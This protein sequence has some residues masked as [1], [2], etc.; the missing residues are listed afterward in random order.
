[1][2]V[3]MSCVLLG[4]HA[5]VGQSEPPKTTSTT[6]DAPAVD[7]KGYGAKEVKLRKGLRNDEWRYLGVVVSIDKEKMVFDGKADGSQLVREQHRFTLYP[8]DVLAAGK[9]LTDIIAHDAYRWE[10]VKVGDTVE[11]LM[12]EDKEELRRY[13]CTIRICRR[14]GDKLPPCQ[15]M[16]RYTGF[17]GDNLF[18]DIDNGLDVSEEDI[19]RLFPPR[20]YFEKG[21]PPKLL[22][23]AGLPEEWR[24]KLSINRA[25][26]VEEMEKKKDKDLKAP[27]PPEKK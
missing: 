2:F 12:K 19:T 20:W 3:A 5:A 21:K 7:P 15:D 22:R 23:P 8:I 1:M 4:F 27:P 11:V 6:P 14:P 24:T 9:V 26:I 10:D 18:N 25:K 17:E 16:K 13:V